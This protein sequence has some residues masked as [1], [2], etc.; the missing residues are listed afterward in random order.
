MQKQFEFIEHTADLGIKVYGETLEQLFKN[1]ALGMYNIICENFSFISP[2][3][4]YQNSFKELDYETLLISFLNELIYQTFV[5]KIVFCDFEI[6]IENCKIDFTCFGEIYNKQK[7]GVMFELKSATFHN[8][9]ITRT[10]TFFE[11]VI[12]F[13]V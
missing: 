1:A 6:K 5:N 9:K 8:L 3:K 11:C 4:L 10:S 12:I 2:Q 7:H 13:D